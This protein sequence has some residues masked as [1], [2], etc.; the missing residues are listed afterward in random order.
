VRLL[1]APAVASDVSA[2]T[3][4]FLF[5]WPRYCSQ[6]TASNAPSAVSAL[7][8]SHIVFSRD[9]VFGVSCVVSDASLLVMW[10]RNFWPSYVNCTMKITWYSCNNHLPYRPTYFRG[11]GL[12]SSCHRRPF[13]CRTLQFDGSKNG[14]SSTEILHLRTYMLYMPCLR[15]L[16][17]GLPVRRPGFNARLVHIGLLIDTVSKGQVSLRVF[18]FPCQYRSPNTPYS[19]FVQMPLTLSV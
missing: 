17:S 19:Y 6:C 14:I 2:D 3:A 15:R 16:V 9:N 4:A 12:R 10:E 5:I 11:G 18:I 1:H 7:W 13:Q 8:N